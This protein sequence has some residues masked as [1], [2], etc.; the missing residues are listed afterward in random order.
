MSPSAAR[1]AGRGVR[2]SRSPR[3]ALA[4]YLVLLAGP[5]L[6]L[7]GLGLRAVQQQ[8]QA[9]L[10]LADANRR[11]TEQ[12][13]VDQV[14]RRIVSL[15]EACLRDPRLAGLAGAIDWTSPAS[16]HQARRILADVRARHPIAADFFAL[17]GDVVYLPRSAEALQ[18]PV[19]LSFAGEAPGARPRLSALVDLAEQAD[20]VANWPLALRRWQAVHAAA[21]SGEVRAF[22]LSRLAQG[23]ER[24]GDVAAAQ[25]A[26]AAIALHHLDAFD[27]AGRPRALVAGAE[28]V[29]LAQRGAAVPVSR[30]EGDVDRALAAI[31]RALAAG[32]WDLTDDE[33]AY[34][35]GRIGGPEGPPGPRTRTRRRELVRAL[36]GHF[37][38]NGPLEADQVY[39]TAF[40]GH[41][42]FYASA[43]APSASEGSPI[44]GID[45]DLDLV[46]TQ[47][48]AAASR[49]LTGDGRVRLAAADEPRTAFRAVL[50]FWG[51][52]AAASAGPAPRHEALVFGATTAA[53]LGLLVLGVLLLLRDV[54]RER[55]TAQVRTNLVGGV[56]H[57][58]KTPLSVIR[59][60]SEMLAAEPDAPRDER[61]SFYEVISAESLRLSH[62]IERV[63]DFSQVAQGRERYELRP[64]RL[65]QVTEQVVTSYRPY[66]RQQR[67]DLELDVSDHGRL[68]MADAE[69]VSRALVSLLENAMKYC[70]DERHIA[71][72]TWGRDG[73]CALEVADRGI[74]IAEADRARLFERFFRGA[75]TDGRGGYGLG[76][77]LVRH[78]MEAHG[79]R[80]E[81][82][83]VEGRGST[84]RLVFPSCDDTVRDAGEGG[85]DAAGAGGRGR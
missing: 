63:L 28:L 19:P 53:V 76:L 61:R 56:G 15:G 30:R 21:A 36:R 54:A 66:L 39:T 78:V 75:R 81:V 31:R 47:L 9:I 34:F 71:V 17:G 32:Y 77:Y 35:A 80:V 24:T 2:S 6:V 65:G 44:L 82:D 51:V 67:F 38:H 57:E 8:R 5:T 69:A 72:R 42:V 68:V 73:E 27:G 59:L 64:L 11:L 55:A 12:Q 10:A 37:R 23:A 40:A 60:Y 18:G 83:S 48:L 13:F 79:G 16:V 14:E 84:F 25:H 49:E 43:G 50:P 22:A 52:T 85:S 74:G 3:R 20:R 29:R 33:A 4:L 46:R 62:L 41:Q 26:L 45:V 1:T 58:L 7:L 70:G